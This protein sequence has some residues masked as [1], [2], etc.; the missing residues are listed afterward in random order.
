MNS[1]LIILVCDYSIPV[2][3]IDVWYLLVVGYGLTSPSDLQ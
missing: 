1:A 2:P 3:S